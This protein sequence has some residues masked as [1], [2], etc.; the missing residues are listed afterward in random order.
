MRAR[1]LSLGAV[2][3]CYLF[4]YTGRQTFDA[5]TYSLNPIA[6]VDPALVPDPEA[7]QYRPGAKWPVSPNA[8]RWLTIP[9]THRYGFESI[10]QLFEM[11][12][13]SAGAATGGQYLP[14]LGIAKGAETATGQSLLVAASDIDVALVVDSIEEDV[15][16]PMCTM[17][18][19]MEQQFLPIEGN[20]ILRS[21]GQKAIP[22]LRDG[23]AIRRNQMQGTRTYVWTGN[24]ISEQR[25]QFQKIGGEF[26]QI[27]SKVQPDDKGRV[28]LWPFLKNFYRSFGFPDADNIFL[29]REVGPGVEP[30]LEHLVLAAGH[31]MPPKLGEKYLDHLQMHDS[32]LPKAEIE[33]WADALR[34]HIAETLVVMRDDPSFMASLVQQQAAPP[35]PGVVSPPAPGASVPAAGAPPALSPGGPPPGS[36]LAMR[37]AAMQRARGGR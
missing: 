7:M 6:A 23:M 4:Y 31:P 1:R 29:T 12:Q 5:Q 24:H 32:T 3:F 26:L 21:L 37:L 27:I 9:P 18:D 25:E 8:V 36:M 14:T 17:I 33:G 19:A 34:K 11:I 16:Q 22:L 10:R 13:E 28:N 15:L 20:R 35:P 2:M 30:E